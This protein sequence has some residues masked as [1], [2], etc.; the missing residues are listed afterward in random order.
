MPF[1]PGDSNFYMSLLAWHFIE[2]Y[3]YKKPIISNAVSAKRQ[4]LIFD[5]AFYTGG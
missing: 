3:N 2:L 4:I 1:Y 5:E